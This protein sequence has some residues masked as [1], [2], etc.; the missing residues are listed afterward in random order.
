M[1]QKVIS[2]GDSSCIPFF[3]FDKAEFVRGQIK[4]KR[5]KKVEEKNRYDSAKDSDP[6]LKETKERKERAGLTVV[7]TKFLL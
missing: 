2:L 7:I 4:E 3:S 1:I 6:A 5:D